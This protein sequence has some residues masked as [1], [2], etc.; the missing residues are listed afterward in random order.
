MDAATIRFKYIV[1]WLFVL[2]TFLLYFILKMYFFVKKCIFFG[3]NIKIRIIVDSVL[4]VAAPKRLKPK[5][6]AV[7]TIRVC[8]VV[9]IIIVQTL[10]F[11]H[12]K[13]GLYNHLKT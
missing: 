10:N 7:S 11:N 9:I 5:I 2:V 3:S 13:L 8:T 4:I 6:V 1:V 12:M